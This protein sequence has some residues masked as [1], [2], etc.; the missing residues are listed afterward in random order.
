MNR[1]KI[2]NNLLKI[3][4]KKNIIANNQELT[5]YNKDWRGFYNYKSICLVFPKTTNEVSRILKLCFKHNIKVVPQSGNTSLTGASVPSKDSYEIIIS[6]KKMNKLLSIDKENMLIE[7]ESG[8]IL[9]NVKEYA[10][11]NNYYF[12]LNL[13]SSGSCLI[14]GNISTN[15]GGINVLK[16]GTMRN[17]LQGL[18]I[19]LSDGSIVENMS[20]MKK[21]NTGY[22][23]KNIFCGSEGT[24]GIITKALLKIYPKP[25]DYYHCFFA[26][27]SINETI[28]LFKILKLDFY[29]TLES[30]E[31]I[32]H[33]AIELS[34]KHKFLKKNFFNKSYENYLLCKFVLYEDKEKFQKKFYKIMKKI[35][36]KYQ[37]VIIAQS[38]QQEKAFWKFRDDL[39]TCYKLEGKYITNDISMP[40]NNLDNFIKIASKK[41]NNLI[42]GTIFYPF[43][44]LGDGNIHFNLILP[45]DFSKNFILIREKIYD[46]VNNLVFKNNGSISAEHGIGMIKRKSLE[47]FK[48]KNEIELMK[49]I[50]ISLD[51]KNILNPGK[52]LNLN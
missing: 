39:V 28:D 29:E 35:K 5:K 41:I 49:K 17:Y 15:A 26:F 7:V 13:S 33:K 9:D 32:P 2:I 38:I 40:L 10:E 43:G 27:N 6:L 20:V 21:D 19:V 51:S 22:D 48:S 14:G 8:I 25:H 23:I 50:K 16:Y 42:P 31:I 12:P 47:K 18:E 30:A 3:L 11:K 45:I 34:L 4:P 52:V 36:K 1:Q 24:L 37:D 44:H 46:L